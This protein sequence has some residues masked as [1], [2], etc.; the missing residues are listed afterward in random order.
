MPRSGV[1]R[2]SD[3]SLAMLSTSLTSSLLRSAPSAARSALAID[4]GAS[5]TFESARCVDFIYRYNLC[6]SCSQFDLL[7]L[8][9]C[10]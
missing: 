8:I 6:E 2:T 4:S 10:N 7:P 9:Y 3:L 5:G 1:E